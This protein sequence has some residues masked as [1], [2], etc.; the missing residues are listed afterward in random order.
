MDDEE[1]LMERDDWGVLICVV[2]D[3]V[4]EGKQDAEIGYPNY[5]VNPPPAGC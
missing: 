5:G 2:T 1:V 4:I 3:L